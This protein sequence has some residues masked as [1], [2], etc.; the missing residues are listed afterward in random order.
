MSDPIKTVFIWDECGER[1]IRFFT[2][3]GDYR[4]FMG[5]YLNSYEE[6]ENKRAHAEQMQSELE[7]LVY[8]GD[9]TMKVAPMGGFPTHDVKTGAHVIVCGVHP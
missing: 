1:P 2:L 3:P 6:N 4:R 9:G 8:N 7:L 5:V